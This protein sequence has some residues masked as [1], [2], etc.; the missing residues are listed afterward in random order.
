MKTLVCVTLLLVSSVLLAQ[1]SN[2]ANSPTRDSKSPKDQVTVRG[3]VSQSNGDYILMKQDPGVAYQLES[4]GKTRL[5]NYFGQEVE[6]KGRKFST[7]SSSSDALNK[8]GSAAPVT[9]KIL[10]IRTISRYC[11]SPGVPR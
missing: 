8:V 10:S 6:I 2:S 3:C 11:S 4:T 7:L 5:H 1:D 9:L